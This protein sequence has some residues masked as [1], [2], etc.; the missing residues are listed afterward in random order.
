[1]EILTLEEAIKKGHTHFIEEEGERLEEFAQL[2][3][4]NK[5]YF[6]TKRCF[7]V[8]MQ[9]PQHYSIS[10][11]KI[12]ELIT[13]Y[14]AGQEEVADE[15]ENLFNVADQHDYSKLADELNEKFKEYKYYALTTTQVIF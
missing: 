6:K 14:V 4:F 13:D 1:M 3:D 12:K 5:E 2:D 15:D 7:I 11:E 8:D 10:A 9:N